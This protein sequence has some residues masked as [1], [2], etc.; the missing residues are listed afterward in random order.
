MRKK[1]WACGLAIF[2]AVGLAGCVT[3]ELSQRLLER[4][5]DVQ[6]MTFDLAHANRTNGA[7][8]IDWKSAVKLLGERNLTLQQA[9]IQIE[10]AKRD[11]KGQWK[12]WLPRPSIYMTL[13]S[14]LAQL[15][16]LSS[17]DLD[18]SVI[19]PLNIPNPFTERAM[20]FQLALTTLQLQDG[21]TLSY[22]QQVAA[23]YQLFSQYE[24]LQAERSRELEM[25]RALSI[26]GALRNL[27]MDAHYRESVRSIQN[28]LAQMLNLPGKNPLPIAGSR[29]KLDYDSRIH[30]LVP[31]K[32]YGQLAVR[33]YAYQI[34]AALLQ[35]KGVKF[36]QWPSLS[37]G[38]SMPPIYQS[39]YGSS[40]GALDSQGIYL[41]S[42]LSKSYDLTGR[43]VQMI[44]SA[45]QN[46]EFV[47]RSL[48]QTMDRESREW[49]AL[50]G[51]YRQ[52]MLKE[53][54]ANER[55]QAIRKID[56]GG[57]AMSDLKMVR[58]AE[59]SLK[60]VA[61]AKEQLV[62]QLWIWDEEKWN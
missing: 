1:L 51:R 58:S 37:L 49:I 13:Q 46:T 39:N 29:P 22:R 23:L 55:V 14:S 27:E 26:D 17:S 32:N 47:K 60:S 59:S 28:S 33:L 19:A 56:S 4:E 35:E 52:M 31:G 18:T 38:G 30:R 36:S 41:F 2:T 62:M 3:K 8:M 40:Y 15:G 61:R 9:R 54:L 11:Q 45:E 16:N 6:T 24:Y 7:Y 12:T 5:V 42:G 25:S 44:K 53:R 43:D 20:A 48:R 34:E 57:A 50:K 10:Q 21:Y